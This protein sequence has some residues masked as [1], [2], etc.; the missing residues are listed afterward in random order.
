MQR[1]AFVTGLSAAAFALNARAGEAG[2][3]PVVG[4]V[5]GATPLAEMAGT[6]PISP[7]A[8][9]FVHGLRDLGWIEGQNIVIE[10]RSVEGDP[11]RAPAI[12]AEL[13]ERGVTVIAFTATRQNIEA[14]Q[15]ATRTIPL[16]A[17]FSNDPV[18]DGFVTSLAHPGGVLTGLA[19]ITG[20]EFVAKRLQYLK[21]MA[22]GV[23]RVA[24]LGPQDLWESYHKATFELPPIFARVDRP[25]QF[26]EAFATIRREQADGLYASSGTV[27]YAYGRRIV[28]FA[29]EQQ[30]PAVYAVRESVEAGGLLSYG[31]N[32]PGNYRQLAEMVNKILR[33]AKPD[34]K[35]VV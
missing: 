7:V 23:A 9:G 12:F 8:R 34:R 29:A 4:L 33:G 2:R 11:Q 21:E 16:V 13:A 15:L 5:F 31:S 27:N 32:V 35:S 19:S 10:R 26:E 24:F 28:A 1:R 17:S 3:L 14:A 25:D 18:A 22:P 6:D 30:L 20:P